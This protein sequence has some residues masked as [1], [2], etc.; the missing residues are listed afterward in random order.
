MVSM[1]D[2]ESLVNEVLRNKPELN[3]ESLMKKIEQKKNSVG[4]GYLTD[5]GALFLIAGELGVK[6]Q[7]APQTETTLK[8]LQVGANDITVVARILSI[9]PISTYRKKEGGEGRY[10]RLVLFDG[11][12]TV[13]FML[14][15]ERVSDVER[16][17]LGPGSAVRIVGGYVKQGLDGRPELGLGRRGSVEAVVEASIESRLPTLES[18]AK[19]IVE[20]EEG[21]QYVAL[22]CV[23]S[24]Q[25]R[26][27]D[28]YRSDGSPGTLVQFKIRGDGQK[29]EYRVVIWNAPSVPPVSPGQRVIL[30][31]LKSKRSSGGE[32]EL[33]GDAGSAVVVLREKGTTD[34]RVVAVLNEKQQVLAVNADK[35]VEALKMGPDQ[36]LP[37]VGDP[38]RILSKDPSGSRI[39]VLRDGEASPPDLQGLITKIN[40]LKEEG[41]PIVLDVI[42]LSH[43]SL[44]DVP[45]KDGTVVKKGEILVGDDTGEIKA[46]AWRDLSSKVLGYEPG[47]RIRIVGALPRLSRMGVWTLLL[48]EETIIEKLRSV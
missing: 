34:L 26:K 5:Q 11:E 22:D 10:R 32:I 1:Y 2:F 29:S 33:H 17:E 31:N 47:E 19:K 9:Y 13:R 37:N 44:L 30:T 23:V 35:K 20:L 36:A 25:P 28:F 7:R 39:R 43:G 45:L 12:R 24:S 42:V 18:T 38:I 6:L 21:R 16:L 48:S 14:W 8:D 4:A 40:D 41:G 27:T 15:E 3:R 46:V